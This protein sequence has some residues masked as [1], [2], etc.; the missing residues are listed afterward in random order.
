MPRVVGHESA[1]RPATA[2]PA[3]G[4]V[5]LLPGL[6]SQR[7]RAD[8]GQAAAAA[9]VAERKPAKVV[10]ALFSHRRSDRATSAPDASVSA[11]LSGLPAGRRTRRRQSSLPKSGAA[12]LPPVSNVL[13]EMPRWESARSTRAAGDERRAGVAVRGRKGQ[14]AAA[15]LFQAAAA[16][17]P[18]ENVLLALLPPTFRATAAEAR[19]VEPIRLPDPFKP[20]KFAARQSV[21]KLSDPAPLLSNVL[22]DT[23]LGSSRRIVPP[24]TSVVPV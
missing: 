14:R 1:C 15:A 23:A 2:V 12:P 13:P 16:A 18:P 9:E 3:P 7:P 24:E 6:R 22:P 11:K 17:G 19:V 10:L 21:P 8:L 4:N 5:F 20:P